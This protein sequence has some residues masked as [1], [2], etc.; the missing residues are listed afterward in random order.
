M[1]ATTWTGVRPQERVTPARGGRR[2]V[3]QHPERVCWG[4]DLRCPAGDLKCGEDTPRSQHPSEVFGDD[5]VEWSRRHAP[6]GIRV[7]SGHLVSPKET[8]LHSLA[9]CQQRRDFIPRF[10]ELFMA[11]STEVAAKFRFTDFDRQQRMLLHSLQLSAAA[12]EGDPDGLAELTARA[13]THDRDHLDITPGL[14]NLWQRAVVAAARECNPDWTADV[15]TAWHTI[16]GFVVLHMTR[17][18]DPDALRH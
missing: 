18:Y 16:L 10:Y 15:E 1:S 9:R 17:R 8:F 4:C 12:T 13:E 11:S 6:D 14:Y 5:W 7:D 2:A 3:P